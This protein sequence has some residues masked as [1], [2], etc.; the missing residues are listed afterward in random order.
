MMDKLLMNF[1]DL[2]ECLIS[3]DLFESYFNFYLSLP[4]FSRKLQYNRLSGEFIHF[5]SSGY[6]NQDL[7]NYGLSDEDRERVIQWAET[8]RLPYFI[9]SDVYREFLLCKLLSAPSDFDSDYADYWVSNDEEFTNSFHCQPGLNKYSCISENSDISTYEAGTDNSCETSSGQ[10][11]QSPKSD[12]NSPSNEG[13]QVVNDSVNSEDTGTNKSGRRRSREYSKYF[14]TRRLSMFEGI[15]QRMNNDPN[16]PSPLLERTSCEENSLR[17]DAVSRQQQQKQ[18]RQSEP[19]KSLYSYYSSSPSSRNHTTF[20]TLEFVHE[21]L[22]EL[23][24]KTSNSQK[25]LSSSSSSNSGKT[26]SRTSE[27]TLKSILHDEMDMQVIFHEIQA[28]EERQNIPMQQLKQILLSSRDGMKDFMAYLVTTNGIHLIDFWLDCEAIKMITSEQGEKE[29]EGEEAD[30]GCTVFNRIKMKFDLIRDLEDLYLLR[31]TP[32]ARQQLFTSVNSISDYF[33]T[34]KTRYTHPEESYLCQLGDMMFDF[35]QQDCLR[36]LKH[37]WLPRWLLHWEKIIRQCQFVPSGLGGCTLFYI[38]SECS[39]LGKGDDDDDVEDDDDDDDDDGSRKYSRVWRQKTSSTNNTEMFS[40]NTSDVEQD[41]QNN[42]NDDSEEHENRHDEYAA[43][44]ADDD[45]DNE[46]EEENEDNGENDEVFE[47]EEEQDEESSSTPRH[48]KNRDSSKDEKLWSQDIYHTAV[49][50]ALTTTDGVSHSNLIKSDLNSEILKSRISQRLKPKAPSSTLISTPSSSSTRQISRTMTQISR[51]SSGFS[52]KYN[53]NTANNDNSISRMNYKSKIPFFKKLNVSWTIPYDPNDVIG[54]KKSPGSKWEAL[55]KLKSFNRSTIQ[56]EMLNNI[57]QKSSVVIES[58]IS[59]LGLNNNDNNSEFLKSSKI[60]KC[61]SKNK[62]EKQ[63]VDS[64]NVQLFNRNL[65]VKSLL[66]ERRQQQIQKQTLSSNEEDVSKSTTS[67]N[68]LIK[69]C[70]SAI[71]ADAASG[72]PFQYYLERNDLEDQSRMLGFLQA[73]QD[74]TRQNLSPMPNRY[75]K[76]AKTWYIVNNFL[77][78]D[79]RWKLNIN[80][81]IVKEIIQTV[82]CKKD[83]ISVKIFDPIKNICLNELYP[84]WIEYLKC[85]AFHFACAAHKS[86]SENY[87]APKSP[88]DFDVILGENSNLIVQRKPIEMPPTTTTTTSGIH[89]KHSPSWEYLTPTEKDERIRLKLEQVKITEKERRKAILAARRRQREALKPKKQDSSLS[90]LIK[91]DSNQSDEEDHELNKNQ[92]DN[93]QEL[94]SRKSSSQ[95]MADLK[96]LISNKLLISMFQEW[97]HTLANNKSEVNLNTVNQ[98]AFI[99]DAGQYLSMSK[100]QFNNM[101]KMKH[102]IDKANRIYTN[103]LSTPCDKP[104]ELPPKFMKRLNQ[105]KDRPSSATLKG[106]RDYHFNA[107]SSLFNE[108]L[109]VTAKKFGLTLSQLCQMPEID[110][111]T[112]VGSPKTGVSQ[113]GETKQKFSIKTR[114]LLEDKE[115]LTKLLKRAAFQPFDFRLI[116]FYQYLVD[117][118]AKENSPFIDQD[119]IFHIEALRFE[120]L[121]RG[122]IEHALLKKKVLCILQT[123]LE[124]VFPPQIQIGLPNEVVNRL[125]ARIH[126]QTDHKGPITLNLFDEAM[127]LTFNE[128]LPFWAGF[129]RNVLS[130][131]SASSKPRPPSNTIKSDYC[132]KGGRDE[133]P[134]LLSSVLTYKHHDM[135]ENRLKLHEEWMA[136]PCTDINLPK[137]PNDREANSFTYSIRTGVGWRSIEH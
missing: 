27:Y 104:I 18:R 73:I 24:L 44:A 114:P 66:T 10:N 50:N 69:K 33:M 130:S 54:L 57:F 34:M 137:V 78:L 58:F 84:Y 88:D 48:H 13:N 95:K 63:N 113:I 120:E 37:Y 45:D 124:S 103:Y 101:E 2:E 79:S 12:V 68:L 119:L 40:L 92:S 49:K 108:F 136:S 82:Q 38:P 9:R 93:Q 16:R 67:L 14:K 99:L 128:I 52:K 111:A 98:L 46:E 43:A 94:Q 123:F 75:T 121:H 72:G 11:N 87:L 19:I 7:G 81:S 23:R 4:V 17:S 6:H 76:L 31:L 47:E 126:R 64:K 1:S 118:G 132:C 89:L 102:K 116:L 59:T 74:Y 106:L 77:R 135:M 36:R 42:D 60:E 90:G 110:L 100:N 25:I 117:Y 96:L 35:V 109:N 20:N 5:N 85:D 131:K 62:T 61:A 22:K 129:K 21:S 71:H 125:I 80:L 133:S 97:L 134:R 30:E 112:L 3:D 107:L 86:K 55:K 122:H 56:L 65:N 29:K 32:K 70:L 51:M 105:E 83:M 8:E 39:P 53:N 28:M 91:V 127:R 15:L 115:E 41:D 26:K